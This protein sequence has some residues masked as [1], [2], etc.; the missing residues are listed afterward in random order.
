MT[1][2]H[3]R[4]EEI[5][6]LHLHDPMMQLPF[7]FVLALSESAH[8]LPSVFIE[9]FVGFK[10]YNRLDYLARIEVL[11][12]RV[13]VQIERVHDVDGLL[14]TL[15]RLGL[16]AMPTEPPEGCHC[17]S[18]HMRTGLHA[19]GGPGARCPLAEPPEYGDATLS[20]WT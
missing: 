1:T 19:N 10:N 7:E 13:P 18:Y 3:L 11:E 8:R 4:G 15:H 17:R 16:Y 6:N 2:V 14:P 12:P 9:V 5:G 20:R